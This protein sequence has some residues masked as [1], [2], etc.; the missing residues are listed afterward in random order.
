MKSIIFMV[1]N[2]YPYYSAT[3]KC[4]G[5]IADILSEEYNI[6]VICLKNKK[7]QKYK[8]K[9]NNQ[10]IIRITTRRYERRHNIEEKIDNSKSIKKFFYKLTKIGYRINDYIKFLFSP[11]SLEKDLISQYLHELDNIKTKVDLIIPV[12][13]PFCS[14]VAANEYVK[15]NKNTKM[16]PILFDSFVESKTLHKN[17]LNK[18]IKRNIHLRIEKDIISNSKKMLIMHTQRKHFDKYFKKY[19]NVINYIEHPLLLKPKLNNSNRVARGDELK[20]LYAGTFIKNYVKPHYFLKVLDGINE[21]NYKMNFLIEGNY[22]SEIERF[23]RKNYPKIS[24]SGF[25]PRSELDDIINDSDILI[26]IAEVNGIQMSSKI[27]DYM[28]IGKPIVHFYSKD[29]D[30]NIKILKNYPKVL[31]IK[32]DEESLHENINIFKEFCYKNKGEKV[33]FEEVYKSNYNA[34]PE[35]IVNNYIIKELM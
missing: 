4:A 25:V 22:K 20:I 14:V 21:I 23:C 27:F 13:F 30:I 34:T 6:K 9:Y 1:G 11:V 15:K 17:N 33:G 3:G 16:I 18:R 28:S 24:L 8:E 5:N 31:F 19:K 2:Y 10:E 32:D 29:D 35:Y 26:S 12:A 7:N